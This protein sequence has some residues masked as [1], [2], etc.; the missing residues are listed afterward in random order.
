[1]IIKYL[2]LATIL[3][4]NVSVALS[5]VTIGNTEA[6]V[7]GALLQLKNIDGKTNGE[8]N[9]TK[10]LGLPRVALINRFLLDPMIT[11]A[12]TTDK[13]IHIGLLVYNT[14]D[15]TL[16]PA[17]ACD[18]I[19]DWNSFIEKG[20][21]VWNGTEWICLGSEVDYTT[22]TP[23]GWIDE[24]VKFVKDHEGNRYPVRK[25]GDAGVFMLENL[26]TTSPVDNYRNINIA[27][28]GCCGG[29][30][31]GNSNWRYSYPSAPD[32]NGVYPSATDDTF[33]KKYPNMGLR[34][35]GYLAFY[36]ETGAVIQGM[37]PTGWHIPSLSEFN[38]MINEIIRLENAGDN[39]GVDSSIKNKV[40]DF[41]WGNTRC[42][43]ED[44]NSNSDFRG[45]S[46]LPYKGGMAMLWNGS[47]SVSGQKEYGTLSVFWV[48][49]GGKAGIVYIR[50]NE[51]SGK[52]VS[53][54]IPDTSYSFQ[55]SI[56]CMKNNDD[57]S[58][59]E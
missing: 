17:S 11:S 7:E 33:F 15:K 48:N 44:P 39:S 9:S 58:D 16:E 20:L 53:E 1:M 36:K 50:P 37:C 45:A 54:Q 35:N 56:R 25:F 27:I 30:T 12:T 47:N 59:L 42:L 41:R 24:S 22:D 40:Y 31:I 57:L 4:I 55:Y 19:P 38:S 51:S 32:S 26:R 13:D 28:G 49:V 46:K 6:P 52:W 2:T 29:S 18:A 14:T 3:I 23:P 21:N 34:Y 43:P 5:Q 10:S 8:A